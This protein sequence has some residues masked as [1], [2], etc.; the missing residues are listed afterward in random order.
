MK[1]LLVANFRPQGRA[2]EAQ[3]RRLVDAQIENSLALGWAARDIVIVGNLP[4]DAPVTVVRAPLNES[5]L[6]GSKMFALEHL[7]QLDLI[8][9]GEIWWAHDLDAWQNHWFEPPEIADIA[10]AEYSRPTFNG[11]SVFLR[12]TARDLVGEIT[13]HIRGH[14]MEREEPAIDRILRAP[15]HASRVTVLNSTYNVGCSAYAIRYNRSQQPILVSHF[16]PTGGTSWRTH[17]WG[18]NRIHTPSISPRLEELLVRHFHQGK[19]PVPVHYRLRNAFHLGDCWARLNYALRLLEAGERFAIYLPN[20]MTRQIFDL[21]EIGRLRPHLLK[22]RPTANPD[23]QEIFR[24]VDTGSA[25]YECVYFPTRIAWQPQGWE[26][27][28]ALDANWQREAKIPPDVDDIIP[29]LR[30]ALPHCTFVP[31][32]LPHQASV[33]ELVARMASL[34]LVLSVDN[35]IAHV[36]RSVGVPLFLLEHLHALRRGFP[37]SRCTYTKVTRQDLVEKITAY[38][39]RARD[40]ADMDAPAVADVVDA[41]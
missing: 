16:H 20:E 36:A 24:R 29:A 33:T 7:F 10:L 31:L 23:S 13:A 21:L 27:G 37:P 14:G 6:T 11:G 8:R 30:E 39:S 12:S 22:E 38:V 3:L 34:R 19:P 35:G 17:V 32:G 4:L 25:A 15:R 40:S 1:N 18:Y 41:V 2:S 5:C 28:Y 9:D 26:I